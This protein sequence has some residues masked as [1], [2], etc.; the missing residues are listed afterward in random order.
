M[1]KS[2]VLIFVSAVLLFSCSDVKTHEIKA[3]TNTPFTWDFSENRTF[4]YSFE[5]SVFVTSSIM[6]DD[7]DHRKME[8]TAEMFVEVKDKN[9]ANVGLRNIKTKIITIN[10]D[11]SKED[12]DSQS[13]PLIMTEGM[14]PKGEFEDLQAAM[15]FQ[16]LVPLP[17][18]N[19]KKGETVEVPIK[20]PF[21]V[22]SSRIYIRGSI[23]LK[24]VADG[25]KRKRTCA[26]LESKIDVSEVE[27]P[28]EYAKSYE[29]Y[30]KGTGTY[31]FDLENGIYVG[32]DVKTE[33]KMEIEPSN[34]MAEDFSSSMYMVNKSEYS[35]RL[36]KIKKSAKP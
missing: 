32:G 24:Y 1:V 25:I 10:E 34:E 30:M 11:G 4:A 12:V 33:F 23:E 28:E 7:L 13:S 26:V 5:Q 9:K 17:P 15:L 22:G 20:I 3:K 29:V 14:S 31:Y 16:T 36:K 19:L 35:F 8:A 27:I 6:D 18:E 21:N 2:I